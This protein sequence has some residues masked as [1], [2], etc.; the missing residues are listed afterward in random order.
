MTPETSQSKF[1]QNNFIFYF[2]LRLFIYFY[3][4][5]TEE[6]SIQTGKNY[7]LMREVTLVIINCEQ[8]CKNVHFSSMY[9]LVLECMTKLFQNMTFTFINVI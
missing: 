8:T 7:M 3:I 5:D 4:Q 1:Q 2:F 9:N 6:S